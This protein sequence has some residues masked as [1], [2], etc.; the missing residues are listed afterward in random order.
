[1]TLPHPLPYMHVDCLSRVC[2]M[3][4]W[5][6]LF[7][8]ML[9]GWETH[10]RLR[11]PAEGSHFLHVG[12]VVQ[13]GKLDLKDLLSYLPRGRVIWDDNLP[14]GSLTAAMFSQMQQKVWT[15]WT[16][17]FRT[18]KRKSS[19]LEESVSTQTSALPG[20]EPLWPRSHWADDES[21][22]SSSQSWYSFACRMEFSMLWKEPQPRANLEGEVFAGQAKMLLQFLN[23]AVYPAPSGNPFEKGSRAEAPFVILDRVFSSPFYDHLW[24]TS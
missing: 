13:Q 5:G 12:H 14:H 18:E 1:M 10:R 22:S 15:H 23:M 19:F 20:Q 7:P 6:M 24:L 4:S 21:V 2:W 9:P 3:M 11:I 16:W 17:T 8:H